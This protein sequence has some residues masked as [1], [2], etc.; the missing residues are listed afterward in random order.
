MILP[1]HEE[2]I[3]RLL[4]EAFGGNEAAGAAWLEKDF[5][6]KTPR[7]LLTAMRAGQVIHVLKGM[8]ERRKGDPSTAPC[9]PE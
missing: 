7:D 5:G 3:A 2:Q 9:A 4:R 6:A 8:I 1:A